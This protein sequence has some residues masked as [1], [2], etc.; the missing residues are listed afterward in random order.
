MQSS[1]GITV[2]LVGG[3]AEQTQSHASGSCECVCGEPSARNVCGA[4]GVGGRHPRARPRSWRELTELLS[5]AQSVLRPLGPCR[6]GQVSPLPR[7]R[8]GTCVPLKPGEPVSRLCCGFGARRISK[9]SRVWRRAAK[10]PVNK[11][12]VETLPLPA[13]DQPPCDWD[14]VVLRAGAAEGED[15]AA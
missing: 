5:R 4:G 8:P 2:L 15:G 1:G 3:E 6:E 11:D 13:G 12:H 9:M 10:F 7:V 14:Y